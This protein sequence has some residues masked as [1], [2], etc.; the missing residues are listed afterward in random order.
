MIIALR[1]KERHSLFLNTGL[2]S[3]PDV[4]VITNQHHV[5]QAMT[6]M[7]FWQNKSKMKKEKTHD[8]YQTCCEH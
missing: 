7:M 1:S 2:F 4:I 8:R 3:V 6:G 5:P